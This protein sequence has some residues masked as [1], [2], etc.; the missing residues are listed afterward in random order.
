MPTSSS[1][2]T[3]MRMC[4]QVALPSILHCWIWTS[5]SSVS[6]VP[7]CISPQHSKTVSSWLMQ[8]MQQLG[9]NVLV[10][11]YSLIREALETMGVSFLILHLPIIGTKFP[12][13]VWCSVRRLHC[14]STH[15]VQ[16]YNHELDALCNQ[17]KMYKWIY[18]IYSNLVYLTNNDVVLLMN[19]WDTK[20]TQLKLTQKRNA[21]NSK[22]AI[23]NGVPRLGFGF[24]G[25][26]CLHTFSGLYWDLDLLTLATYLGTVS[27]PTILTQDSYH[28]ARWWSRY[29]SHNLNCCD[30]QR[31]LLHY[32]ANTYWTYG[33]LLMIVETLLAWQ[34]YWKYLPANKNGRNED[35][36]TIPLTPHKEEPPWLLRC[37][38]GWQSIRKQ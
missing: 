2:E 10:H 24:Q 4:T 9:L 26:G 3:L 1:L 18:F 37:S 20:F 22:T 8:F 38:L 35:K 27:G 28:T 36:K 34:L 16:M 15:L 21:P 31:T 17:H 5:M 25:D 29:R 12:N 30:W 11:S 14:K 7:V 6:D 32:S 23:Q 13:I 19:G 33:R